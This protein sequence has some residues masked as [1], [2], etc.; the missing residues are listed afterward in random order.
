MLHDFVVPAEAES[1]ISFSERSSENF[2]VDC[3]TLNDIL[4]AEQLTV[5]LVPSS[6]F[7]LDGL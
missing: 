5:Q 4:G 3:S 6:S 7:L 1:P 2:G